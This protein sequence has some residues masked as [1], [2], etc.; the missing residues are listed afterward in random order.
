[1]KNNLKWL[2]TAALVGVGLSGCL[3]DRG[4]TDLL[5]A[6][7][8][9]SLVTFA[10]GTGGTNKVVS[11]PLGKSYTYTAAVSLNSTDALSKDLTV[12]VAPS[13]AV[14]DAFN[15]SQKAAGRPIYEALPTS[16]YKITNPVIKAGQ[17]DASFDVV[18][19]LP[20]THDLKKNYVI[21]LAITDAS[22]AVISQNLG[23]LTI[24]VKAANEYEGTYA[25]TGV[26]EH[27][28]DGPRPIKEDK[29]LATINENTVETRFA[30]LGSIGWMMQLVINKDNTV[31]LIPTGSSSTATVQFGEN[32]Y[33]PATKTFT[34]NYK[35]AG[36][37]GDRVISE[38][39]VRK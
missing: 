39:L 12:T 22:G 11:F 2:A 16:Y 33:D 19:T 27:P 8:S 26:F 21:P 15:A 13:Q 20:A 38:K 35:Y 23:F 4:Y 24:D 1:M 28:T 9:Q 30:D 18:V 10:E 3:K 31:K 29:K 34:L 6:V 32:K 17:R 37:G 25:S 7:G 36:S 14:L 5:N